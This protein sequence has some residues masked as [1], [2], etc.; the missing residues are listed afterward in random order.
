MNCLYSPHGR[1]DENFEGGVGV[2]KANVLNGFSSGL[3]SN[4]NF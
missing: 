2:F 4:W 1:S 3:H